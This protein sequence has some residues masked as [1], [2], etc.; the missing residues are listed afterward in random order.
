MQVDEGSDG[1]IERY[2]SPTWEKATDNGPEPPTDTLIGD[3]NQD[4]QVDIRDMVIVARA[5][6]S[7]AGENRYDPAADLDL[8]RDIT[9]LDVVLVGK[10]FGE[11]CQR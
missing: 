8:D 4:C 2:I 9:L 7:R 1:T 10:H 3:L 6:G 11:I 5:F